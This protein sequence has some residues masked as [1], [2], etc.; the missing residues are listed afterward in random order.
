MGL[1][2]VRAHILHLRRNCPLRGK[3]TEKQNTLFKEFVKLVQ[4]YGI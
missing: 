1:F 4:I 2:S 3:Y